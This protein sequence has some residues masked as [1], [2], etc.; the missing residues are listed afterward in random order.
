MN[1]TLFSVKYGGSIYNLKTVRE[2]FGEYY[3]YRDR[4]D[5]VN[6]IHCEKSEIAYHQVDI[7]FTNKTQELTVYNQNVFFN[8]TI[9]P[10]RILHLYKKDINCMDG[11]MNFILQ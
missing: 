7:P 3:P 6:E 1:N 10:N 4:C 5:L 2:G 11:N 9:I 8:S